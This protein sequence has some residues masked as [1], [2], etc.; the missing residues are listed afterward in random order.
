M[1]Y[2]EYIIGKVCRRN[3]NHG[4]M[5]DISFWHGTRSTFFSIRLRSREMPIDGLFSERPNNRCAHPSHN[6]AEIRFIDPPPS[7]CGLRRDESNCSRNHS[8]SM[9]ST[10]A[11]NKMSTMKLLSLV[12]TLSSS[13]MG[14][15]QPASRPSFIRP[16]GG[17]KELQVP[18]RVP[19][20]IVL[21]PTEEMAPTKKMKAAYD[22]GIGKNKPVHGDSNPIWANTNKLEATQ[23]L[24]EHYATRDLPSPLL[25]SPE[26]VIPERPAV[27]KVEPRRRTTDA[28]HIHT[29]LSRASHEPTMPAAQPFDRS[30]LPLIQATSDAQLDV[31]T[32]WV[33]MMLHSE[34]IKSI[35]L[36][37]ATF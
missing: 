23:F 7:R 37:T 5:Y 9:E 34:Q 30:T 29:P 2:Y 10:M 21:P 28:L 19:S 3:L 8:I 36:P 6:F 35:S 31:N 26:N 22:L 15:T 14:Y 17:L 16:L 33:E 13:A 24:V 25:G 32:I 11:P 1:T 27:P 4:M 18:R 20:N 12:L